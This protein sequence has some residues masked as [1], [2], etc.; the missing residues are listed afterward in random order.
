M[1][2]EYSSALVELKTFT[3]DQS[4]WLIVKKNE[5]P[6]VPPQTDIEHWLQEFVELEALHNL[7]V[8]ASRGEAPPAWSDVCLECAWSDS[9]L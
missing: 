3:I 9:F 4:K 7:D 8:D 5:T 6:K 1:I 2:V